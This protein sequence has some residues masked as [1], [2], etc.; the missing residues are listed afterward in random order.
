MLEEIKRFFIK[1]KYYRYNVEDF[2]K[3]PIYLPYLQP[4]LMDVETMKCEESIGFKLPAFLIELLKVQNGGYVKSIGYSGFDSLAGIGSNYPNISDLTQQMRSDYDDFEPDKLV[5]L[6]GDGHY[7]ICLDYRKSK[8]N[9][10]LAHIDFE[11]GNDIDLAE[12]IEIYLKGDHLIDEDEISDYEFNKL[13]ACEAEI[14][15]VA[16]ILT[17]EMGCSLEEI[18]STL[19]GYRNLKVI[20]GDEWVCTLSPN[21]VRAGF[22]RPDHEMFTELS[23]LMNHYALRYEDIPTCNTI[24]QG[25][26]KEKNYDIPALLEV[27]GVRVIE[28]NRPVD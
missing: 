24:I 2:W 10:S 26:T 21:S 12:S 4:D 5:A 14:N 27:H 11:C 22:V 23:R 9:P 1:Q 15:E 8:H 17:E 19:R 28:V 25:L 16:A 6:D 18:D 13:Y 3:T 20:Q 7:Y